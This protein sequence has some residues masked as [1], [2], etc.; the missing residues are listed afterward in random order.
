QSQHFDPTAPPPKNEKFTPPAD[1]KHIVVKPGDGL[2]RG[3]A[4]SKRTD[5]Q[6]NAKYE[7][8]ENATDK[9]G[10]PRPRGVFY[11]DEHG[12]ARSADTERPFSA[13]LNNPR[14]N[15]Q[16]SVDDGRWRFETGPE[17]TPP[18]SGRP[19]P[20]HVTDTCATSGEGLKPDRTA[21]DYGARDWHAQKTSGW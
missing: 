19:G 17:N 6:P 13:E 16:Y 7:V 20:Q 18:T 14:P 11:T 5:L 8:Y 10:N 2:R 12:K 1:P 15:T 3:E 4:F 9:D 21:G